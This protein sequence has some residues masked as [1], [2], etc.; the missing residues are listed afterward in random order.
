MTA[1]SV[2]SY[3]ELT[4]R[5]GENETPCDPLMIIIKPNYI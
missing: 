2:A 5:D 1:C 4:L 3:A